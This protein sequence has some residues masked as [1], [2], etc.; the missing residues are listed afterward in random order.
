MGGLTQDTPDSRPKEHFL[1]DP[2][3][4]RRLPFPHWGVELTKDLGVD[5][6][7]NVG[8]SFLSDGWADF[9]ETDKESEEENDNDEA[10]RLAGERILPKEVPLLP[11]EDGPVIITHYVSPTCFF[12]V[13]RDA[14]A[15]ELKRM[16]VNFYHFLTQTWR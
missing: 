8:E 15:A 14:G 3:C 7:L 2:V 4:V 9:Q 10:D 13:N 12:V 11:L 5:L 16:K 1:S 6:F